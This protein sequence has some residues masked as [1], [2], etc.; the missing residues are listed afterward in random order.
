MSEKRT[1]LEQVATDAVQR[2]GF[3]GL[4]FRTLADAVGVKSSS[5]HY[6][7]PEKPDLA[8]A[9]VIEYTESFRA[10]LNDIDRRKRSLRKK[11]EAFFKIFEDVLDAQKFCLCGMM[12]AEVATL[13]EVTRARLTDYFVMVEDWLRGL[14]EAHSERVTS[15]I[16]PRVLAKIVMSGLE[17][18]ILLDRVTGGHERLRAQRELMYQLVD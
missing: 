6:Y 11:L 12:A 18:A 15:D 17:G 1:K 10:Q 7:Y 16:K 13:D 14:F 8:R 4:S 5:V 2:S 9:L 3:H